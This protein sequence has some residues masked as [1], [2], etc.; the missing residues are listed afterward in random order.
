MGVEIADSVRFQF[1]V[2][3]RIA[4][5]AIAAFMLGRGLRHMIGVRAHAITDDF[6]QDGRA[7]AA[8]MLQFF[9]D[10]NA[11]AFTHDEAVAILVPGTAGASRIVVAGGK[12]AHSSESA[13]AHGSDGGFSTTC[14]HDVG[15]LVLDDA[16]GIADGMSAG[17]AG[18]GRGFIGAFG[19]VL[20]RNMSGGEVD[21]GGGDEK[22]RDLARTTVDERLVLAFDHIES[23][24]AGTDVNAD[25]FV[26]FGRDLQA[27]HPNGFIRR[28]E[29]KVDEA[30]H[31]FYFFSLDEIERVEIPDFGGNLAGKRGGIEGGDAIDPT[32]SGG[33]RRPYLAAGMAQRADHADAGDDD[34][35]C[36]ITCLPSRVC[37][38]SRRRRRRCESFRRPRREFRCRRLPRKP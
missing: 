36:Q 21:D 25:A 12:R 15:I 29:R 22:G 4:H 18:R 14:D 23:T 20:H 11:G 30:A 24:D 16:K 37:R 2:A 17:G 28:G 33:E 32:F 6:G 10:Q 7:A 26:I 27:R 13:Y 9:Q 31:F 38:C 34:P 35:P 3:Q 8:G 1:G 19:A 5:D